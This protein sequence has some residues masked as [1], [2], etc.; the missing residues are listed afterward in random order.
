MKKLINKFISFRNK[1]LIF[2]SLLALFSLSI[3][4]TSPNFS[5]CLGGY[6]LDNTYWDT[7][8]N[9]SFYTDEDKLK[10]Y[11]KSFEGCKALGWYEDY[12]ESRIKERSKK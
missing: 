2:F 3:Y 12:F 9:I 10:D 5:Y 6:G 1:E 4:F 7:R 8:P 11:Q